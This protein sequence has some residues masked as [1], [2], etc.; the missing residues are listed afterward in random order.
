MCEPNTEIIRYVGQAVFLSKRISQHYAPC[1]LKSNTHHN[2]WI[3][4]LKEKNRFAKIIILSQASSLEEL[5]RLEIEWIANCRSQGFDLTNSLD[6][7]N[8]S[9]RGKKMSAETKKKMSVASFGIYKRTFSKEE[10]IDICNL[11]ESSIREVIKNKYNISNKT[12]KRILKD[13]N[14]IPHS[15]R[16]DKKHGKKKL[17]EQQVLN[18]RMEYVAGKK[19][20]G[21]KSLAK[22]YNVSDM[23]IRDIISRKTWDWI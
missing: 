1:R 14:I 15:L 16:K 5:D 13:N 20:F 10:E 2:N 22:K 7:G 3:K 6:G 12:I 9:M 21:C 23:N 8:V 19:G 17:T 4:S 18:I 11:Y